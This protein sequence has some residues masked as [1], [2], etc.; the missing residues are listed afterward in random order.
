MVNASAEFIFYNA[1]LSKSTS[2]VVDNPSFV[3]EGHGV[4]SSGAFSD[5]SIGM[6]NHPFSLLIICRKILKLHDILARWLL[7]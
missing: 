1:E 7:H 5:A 3:E 6:N 4:Y 2:A